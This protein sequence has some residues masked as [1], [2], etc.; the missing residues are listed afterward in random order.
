[1]NLWGEICFFW[2]RST[3]C[4]DDDDDNDDEEENVGDDHDNGSDNDDRTLMSTCQAQA[5][6]RLCLFLA[7]FVARIAILPFWE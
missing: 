5:T 2:G 1:M 4:S 7:L 6:N 3:N